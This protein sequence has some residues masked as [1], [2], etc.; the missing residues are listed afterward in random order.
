MSAIMKD[1]ANLS[2]RDF[3]KGAGA[4]VVSFSIPLS[5]FGQV[6]LAPKYA[7]L[8][9]W[10]A[11]GADGKVTVFSGKVE[12]GTGVETAM[13]QLV[14][15][16]LDVPFTSIRMV[17][18]DTQLCPDQGPTVGS[19]TLFLGG[20][21]LR[22]ASAEAR[23]ALVGMAAARLGVPAEQLTMSG[24]V[25][26][27]ADGRRVSYA[28][29]VG[30]KRFEQKLGGGAKPKTPDQLKVVGQSIPRVELPAKVFGCNV[31]IQNLR[32]A[33]MVHGRMVRP[34]MPGATLVSL[35]AGS[36]S[37]L[38]GNVRIARKGNFLAVVADRE[39]QA[40]RAARTLKAVWKPGPELPA[41]ADLPA[42]LKRTRA[43]D[44]SLVSTGNVDTGLSGAAKTHSASYHVPFQLHA[45]IGPSC[46]IADVKPDGVMLYSA[47]QSSFNLRDSVATILGVGAEKVR[48]IW[49]EGSGCYGQNGSDDCTADAALASQLVGKPVRIQWMRAD[50]HAR[51]PMG[52]AMVMDVRGGL[53]AQ[54]NVVA[55]DY[56]V[57]SANH[58][59][60]PAYGMG[61][62]VIAGIE[63]GLPEKY[64]IVGADR[65]ARPSYQFA[66]TKSVLHLLEGSP[67]R[68]SSLRGLGAPQNTF[69]NESFID[70]LAALAGAD[71][72][73]FRLKHL[74][75]PRAIAVLEGVR[76]ISGWTPRPAPRGLNQRGRGV[77]F[78]HY[79]NGGGYVGMVVHVSVDAASG[80]VRV[81]EVF[82]S[83][84]CGLIVNPDGLRNQ[85]EGNIVQTLSRA[86]VEEVTYDRQ[87]VRSVDWV[88]YPILRFSD[89]PERIEIQ[90]INRPDQRSL[91]AGEPACAPVMAAVA[92]AIFDATGAR[93]RSVP[94][95][96]ARVKAARS[97]RA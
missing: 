35:D 13:A 28:E 74:K 90:L 39:E 85:I 42:V 54:G 62:N 81:N 56:Q 18:G 59:A 23:A 64:Q 24:G 27:A 25:V 65:N 5:A 58:G 36:V 82:C 2:R 30:G 26:S 4:L 37:K 77:A 29:L 12:L 34:P 46:A 32:I 8:D 33:G 55:W 41:A 3:L 87:R 71:P 38:P 84:D 86:L 40:I 22:A 61:G 89:M 63:L 44:R 51:E 95:T 53:D 6:P 66:N 68:V 17:M 16:E 43:E 79:N 93:L 57:W 49:I 15:D 80:M 21:Q 88:G 72:L 1:A 92:N 91:G 96:P 14:A 7:T 73:E 50:E 10:L 48:L 52:V 69:A 78:V 31:Y 97:T 19:L 47:T 75:D 70:E 9:A 45:S 67:I 11:V 94:F 60:R 20:P 83:H 76:T